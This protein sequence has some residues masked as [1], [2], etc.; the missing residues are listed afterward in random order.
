[1][2]LHFC[3]PCSSCLQSK[4][5]CRA[6]GGCS[7]VQSDD[8]RYCSDRC[9]DICCQM[10]VNVC[11][12]VCSGDCS[13]TFCTLCL[14][15]AQN[16]A[17]LINTQ[18]TETS[19]AQQSVMAPD[20]HAKWT[21]AQPLKSHWFKACSFSSCCGAG[22]SLRLL[23]NEDRVEEQREL[24]QQGQKKLSVEKT[25]TMVLTISWS[26]SLL[27]WLDKSA[28]NKTS[29]SLRGQAGPTHMTPQTE[30]HFMSTLF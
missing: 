23:S 4:E 11:S 30:L 19:E 6:A 5:E 12:G 15:L 16:C 18:Q 22:V 21:W 26:L 7:C 10:C 29:S 27:S 8:W 13:Y 9:C 17:S 25:W 2:G 28:P 1:M 20:L 24:Q 14:S 3:K